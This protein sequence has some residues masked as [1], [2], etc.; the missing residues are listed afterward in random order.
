[1][2][3]E[4][5]ILSSFRF[6]PHFYCIKTAL[7]SLMLSLTIACLLSSSPKCPPLCLKDLQDL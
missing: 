1:M 4:M 3:A 6:G 7:K 2:K 5:L